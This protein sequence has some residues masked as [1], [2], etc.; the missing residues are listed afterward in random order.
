MECKTQRINRLGQIAWY[1]YSVY[2]QKIEIHRLDTN[3]KS[4]VDLQEAVEMPDEK[5]Q[6][7]NYLV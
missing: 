2:T 4:K 5:G 1:G 6:R 3:E 7:I